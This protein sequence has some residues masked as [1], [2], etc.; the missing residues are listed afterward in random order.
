MGYR[1]MTIDNLGA[2]WLR[3]KAGESNRAIDK[4]LTLDKKTVHGLTS[5]IR[6][7]GLGYHKIPVQ[8]NLS[9]RVLKARISGCREPF[10]H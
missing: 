9:H 2:I 6:G 4:A 1:M 10:V 3:L 7:V 5:R 8:V